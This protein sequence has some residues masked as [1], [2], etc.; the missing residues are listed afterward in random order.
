MQMLVEALAAWRSKFP[1]RFVTDLEIVRL[2]GVP[3]MLCIQWQEVA[4][5]SFTC[6]V[7]ASVRQKYGQEY[8]EALAADALRFNDQ[9]PND[10]PVTA[11]ISKRE[12][13]LVIVKRKH[14]CYIGMLSDFLPLLPKE[15]AAEIAK[16]FEE[17]QHSSETGY[18]FVRLPD[19]FDIL[20]R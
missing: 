8:V 11:M 5:P 7:L 3:N 1:T 14:I 15:A 9:Y 4:G 19:H 10:F 18:G 16:R 13:V 2:G 12:V 17:F 6:Q 20:S